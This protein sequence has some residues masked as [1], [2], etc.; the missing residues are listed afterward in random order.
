VQESKETPSVKILD[1][2]NV[3]ERRSFP[4]RMLIIA[5]GDSLSIVA[6]VAWIF[7]KQAWEQADPHDSQMVLAREIFQTVRAHLPWVVANSEGARP[8]NCKVWSR[9]RRSKEHSKIDL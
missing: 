5:L 3:P 7:G 8:L 2:P 9:F 1:P 6:S 4:P